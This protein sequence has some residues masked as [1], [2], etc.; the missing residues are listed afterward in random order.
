MVYE[1]TV[2]RGPIAA[3]FNSPGPCY[4]LPGLMGQS[5]HDPRS[6]HRIGPSYPF[7]VKYGKQNEDCSPGPAYLIDTKMFRD[8]RDGTPHYSMSS[9]NRDMRAQLKTP[10][11]GAYSPE[12]GG[13]QTHYK[14]PE[15]SFGGRPKSSKTTSKTPGPNAYNADSMLCK[16]VRAGKRTAPSYTFR[17]KT[18]VGSFTE[19][20]AKTPGPASHKVIDPSIQ[21][22]SAP[23][24]SMTSRNRMP[25]DTT[26]KPGPGSHSPE[27][28][29][30][31]R[32]QAPK[33]S[34]GIRHSYFTT[35][36]IIDVLD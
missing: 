21:K 34:F 6:V 20:L 4:G 16:T 24:Y 15:Y 2:P 26:Q 17:A 3:H 31:T 10:G 1:Y 32:R 12:K 23:M 18:Y 13:Q 25:G 29:F 8:G 19:D 5:K 7:G 22:R 11:P 36:L 9:R 27:K 14:H 30:V 35:P 28:V 33:P